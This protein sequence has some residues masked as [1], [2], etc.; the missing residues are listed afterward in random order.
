MSLKKCNSSIPYFAPQRLCTSCI[1]ERD[2]DVPT[3]GELIQDRESWNLQI[4]SHCCVMNSYLHQ[5]AQMGTVNTKFSSNAEGEGSWHPSSDLIRLCSASQHSF[6]LADIMMYSHCQ[7]CLHAA[8]PRNS[9]FQSQKLLMNR[10]TEQQPI[11]FI[12]T[13]AICIIGE[14]RR[15]SPQQQGL[16]G[17]PSGVPK[18]ASTLKQENK[19]YNMLKIP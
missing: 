7:T 5:N 9:S 8:A 16:G 11:N 15:T 13:G 2:L 1:Q 6:L 17:K 10:T 4:F 18:G 19:C 3:P 14:N 12:L